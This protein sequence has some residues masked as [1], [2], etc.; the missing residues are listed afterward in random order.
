MIIKLIIWLGGVGCFLGGL[1]CLLMM[2]MM[3]MMMMM[4]RMMMMLWHRHIDR[5]SKQQEGLGS[6]D[7]WLMWCGVM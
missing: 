1:A 2:M 6:R 7:L 3:M 4:K 5:E